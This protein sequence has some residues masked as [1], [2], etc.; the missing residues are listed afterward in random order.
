MITIEEKE[1]LFEMAGEKVGAGGSISIPWSCKTWEEC[2]VEHKGIA[3]LWF[4][5]E[6]NSTRIVML[7]RGIE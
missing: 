1:K 3:W 7:K 2:Y 4:D 5:D 6:D